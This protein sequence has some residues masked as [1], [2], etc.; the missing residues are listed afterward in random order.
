MVITYL[1]TFHCFHSCI[2]TVNKSLDSLV[3][4]YSDISEKYSKGSISHKIFHSSTM[5]PSGLA[6]LVSTSKHLQSPL[7][8]FNSHQWECRGPPNMTVPAL[9]DVK[10]KIDLDPMLLKIPENGFQWRSSWYLCLLKRDFYLLEVV[11]TSYSILR[12]SAEFKF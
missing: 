12:F 11:C 7:C 4:K 5:L 6:S 1:C 2:R 8:G 10:L 3:L 9:Q